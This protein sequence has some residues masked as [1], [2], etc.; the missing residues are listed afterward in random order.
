MAYDIRNFSIVVAILTYNVHLLCAVW[1]DVCSLD[2]SAMCLNCTN[3][4]SG[5]IPPY[6]FTGFKTV[7][8]T[9]LYLYLTLLHEKTKIFHITTWN[10]CSVK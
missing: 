6:I 1:N 3:G 10:W 2:G 9:Q 7:L 8:V 5:L 4:V